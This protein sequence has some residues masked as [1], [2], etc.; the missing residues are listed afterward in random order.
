MSNLWR[1][2]LDRKKRHT[3]EMSDSSEVIDFDRKEKHEII[4]NV[5]NQLGE[6]CRKVLALYY[7][8]GR[9]MM[10]IAE[11]LNFANADTAKTKKY[12]CKKELDK[13]IKASYTAGDFIG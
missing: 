11:I 3:N 7:F 4:H 8:D 12:K 6:T 10:E 1:K 5:V 13:K 2:E 9:P